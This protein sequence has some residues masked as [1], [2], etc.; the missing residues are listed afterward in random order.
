YIALYREA[1]E[2]GKARKKEI[3]ELLRK[4]LIMKEEDAESIQDAKED[5]ENE[6]D[7]EEEKAENAKAESDGRD[8]SSQHSQEVLSIHPNG[9]VVELPLENSGPTSSDEEQLTPK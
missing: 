2:A 6:S 1:D 5:S 3:F 4:G 9:N 8:G 7:I